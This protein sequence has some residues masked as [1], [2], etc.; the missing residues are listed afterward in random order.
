MMK[1]KF[2][3]PLKFSF[4]KAVKMDAFILF[5]RKNRLLAVHLFS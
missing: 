3:E 5:L 1:V 2:P 4:I